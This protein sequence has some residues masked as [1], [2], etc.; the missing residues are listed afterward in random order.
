[1]AAALDLS[2]LGTF[3]PYSDPTTLSLRWK[4]RLRRYER[5]LVAI[6]VKDDTRKRALLLY[7]VGNEVDKI[8]ATLSDVGEEN[9]YKIAVEKLNEYFSPK[10]NILFEVHKF[11][12]LK[13]ITDETINQYCTRLR[14][15]AVIREFSNSENEIKIQLVEGCLSSR[16][17]RKAIQDDLSLADILNYARSLEITD[18]A[19]KTLEEDLNHLASPSSNVN[20]IRDRQENQE[21]QYTSRDR[22]R[23]CPKNTEREK[24]GEQPNNGKKLCYNRGDNYYAR[25]LNECRAKGKS[26]FE[27]GKR[28]H[29]AATCRSRKSNQNN[30]PERKGKNI[31]AINQGQN[32]QDSSD[33][34]SYVF[35]VSQPVEAS[36]VTRGVKTIPVI[37]EKTHVR[38]II[39]TG[40]TINILDSTTFAEI[41]KKN[42]SLH[43]KPSTQAKRSTLTCNPNLCHFLGNLK[44]SSSQNTE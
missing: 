5:F 34:D 44:G 18:K 27:C 29:F 33:D 23:F 37:I 3:D 25:H 11:R 17:G 40:A 32:N 13:Q 7:A 41:K 16:V 19:V 26:C 15:Q 14:Q 10:K 31:R 4:E 9:D 35:V 38:M 24:S 28:N 30:V 1:M 8:F 22:N 36:M 6:D 2:G 43:L 39:D 42:P 20:A 21:S 12:L